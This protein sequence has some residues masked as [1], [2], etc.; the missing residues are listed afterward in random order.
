MKAC[1]LI[2]IALVAA[3]TGCTKNRC[4]AATVTQ[5]GTPCSVWGIKINNNTYPADSIPSYFKTEGA[6]FCVDYELYQDMRVCACCGGTWV[7][8]ISMRWPD[9]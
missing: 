1:F 2:I 5:T 6:V 8:I 4:K 3:T 7:K 9:E